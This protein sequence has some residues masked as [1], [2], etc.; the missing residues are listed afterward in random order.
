MNWCYRDSEP[1]LYGRTTK[2]F[3][4]LVGIWILGH[5]PIKFRG[6]TDRRKLF[7]SFDFSVG[8]HVHRFAH[9]HFVIQVIN[10]SSD[11]DNQRRCYS[12]VIR[13]CTW[14]RDSLKVGQLG[15]HRF[16]L[17]HQNVLMGTP[18]RNFNL[19]AWACCLVS[20]SDGDRGQN[21]EWS[22]K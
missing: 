12:R 9:F 16:T 14:G 6:L 8:L 22:D 11:K 15:S 2:V 10:N 21:I 19:N 3:P 20:V 1:F 5:D 7:V 4:P 17:T 13:P 18:H